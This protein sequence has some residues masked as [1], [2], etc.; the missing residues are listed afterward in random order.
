MK[1]KKVTIRWREGLQL[2][3][4]ARLVQAALRFHSRVI[5]KCGERVA[6]VRSV[7]SVCALCA[8]MGTVLEL[9]V[10]GDDEAAATRTMEQV[11]LG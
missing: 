11:F 8:T 2:R 3:H 10:S 7:L 6:D 1:T 9:E 4:A 5:L